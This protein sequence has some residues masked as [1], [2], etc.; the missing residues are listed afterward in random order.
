MRRLLEI[1]SVFA[2]ATLGV[3]PAGRGADL[4]VGVAEANI[5][6]P[7]PMALWGQMHT[8]ISKSVES[9]VTAHVVALESRD[10]DRPLDSAIMVSAD[11]I[12]LPTCSTD[13][14]SES[15]SA[16]RTLMCRSFL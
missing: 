5:T 7:Q 14:G 3:A 15:L 6:H 12:G 11:I 1:L 4:Y 2:V 13:C 10:G 9:P 8:R 16:C